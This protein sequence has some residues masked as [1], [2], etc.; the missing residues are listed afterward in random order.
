MAESWSG[1]CPDH[2]GSQNE[3]PSASCTDSIMAVRA[4]QRIMVICAPIGGLCE[5]RVTLLV[6]L[7]V[8]C[9]VSGD[10]AWAEAIAIVIAPRSSGTRSGRLDADGE[11]R[12]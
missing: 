1:D 4:D 6:T 10:S 12:R 3:S 2:S 9:L 7:R 11:E 8:R 5:K